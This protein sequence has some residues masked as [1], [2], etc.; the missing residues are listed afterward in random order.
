[1]ICAEHQDAESKVERQ[2]LLCDLNSGMFGRSVE[3][4]CGP[5]PQSQ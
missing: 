3:L 1:M 5:M 2:I 4:S